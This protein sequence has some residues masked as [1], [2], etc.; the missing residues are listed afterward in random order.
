MVRRS[1]LEAKIK[2]KLLLKGLSGVGKTYTVVKIVEAVVEAGK[3]VVFIDPEWGAERE[4]ELL[5]DEA[6]EGVELRITPEWKAFKFEVLRLDSCFLKVVDG[7]TEAYNLALYFLEERYLR[8]GYYVIGDVEKQIKDKDSF[9][10]PYQSYPK[11]Y[12]GVKEVVNSL[13]KHP[14]H[15]ICTMHPFR[16]TSTQQRLEEDINRKFDTIVELKR[17]SVVEKKEA[18]I[19]YIAY[20]NKHR[21]KAITGKAILENHVEQLVKMFMKRV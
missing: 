13:I 10:L 1:E 4:L 8:L 15:V 6:L 18:V 14:Y 21:G 9:V 2:E 7:L 5:S 16:E 11:V 19:K 12:S 20:L 3:K 17:E